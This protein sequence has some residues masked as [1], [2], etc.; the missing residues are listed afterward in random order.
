[1]KATKL[2]KTTWLRRLFSASPHIHVVVANPATADVAAIQKAA[3]A[4][5]ASRTEAGHPVGRGAPRRWRPA[6][7][8][9]TFFLDTAR[10]REW[11]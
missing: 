6:T 4:W 9:G 7:E 8:D 10:Q 3:G 5:A 1:M 11:L 2:G